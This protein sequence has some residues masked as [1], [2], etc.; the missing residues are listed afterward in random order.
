VLLFPGFAGFFLLLVAE[1][2]VVHDLAH[3]RPRSCRDLDEIETLLSGEGEG[4]FNWHHSDLISFV[5]DQA[6]RREPDSFVDSH[7]RCF[8]VIT[9]RELS[10]GH[11][12][13]VM[14]F[15]QSSSTVR[16]G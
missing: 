15:D 12:P 11:P 5:V 3:D 6:H 9:K 13:L 10:D 16:D 14:V 4:L 2:P 8:G 7:L 1:A